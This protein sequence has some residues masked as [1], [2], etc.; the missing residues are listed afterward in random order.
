MLGKGKGIFRFDILWMDTMSALSLIRF[1]VN[2]NYFSIAILTSCI[3]LTP[4]FSK[5]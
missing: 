1:A 2:L 4:T 5:A 3:E